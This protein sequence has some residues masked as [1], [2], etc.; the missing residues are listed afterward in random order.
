MTK[1]HATPTT[2][3]LVALNAS[4]R[5]S[6]A[7]ELAASL[8]AR[9]RAELLAVFVEDINLL[10]LAE[11]PFAKEIDRASGVERELDNLRLARAQKSRIS[12]VQHALDQIIAKLQIQASFRIVRGHFVQAV[13]ST[14]EELDILFLCHRE[15][16]AEMLSDW[17]R[18]VHAKAPARPSKPVWA[19]FD[20]S[21]KSRQALLIAAELA[22]SE[23]C[24]LCIALPAKTDTEAHALRQGA[25]E[26]LAGSSLFPSF[27]TVSPGDT[28]TLLRQLRQSF[29]RLLVASRDADEMTKALTE[30]GACP[31][32]LV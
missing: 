32:V 31:V 16:P 19:I 10:N 28:P 26:T 21:P 9:R 7:L 5:D 30:A 18:R 22:T 4:R 25:S 3:V 24:Q 12:Q 20:G 1:Q 14:A 11:L 23:P 27:V 6:E 15:E 13:L 8:A 17:R 2:R 29:C